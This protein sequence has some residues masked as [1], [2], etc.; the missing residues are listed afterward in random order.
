MRKKK[1]S[2]YEKAEEK[3][4][5]ITPHVIQECEYIRQRVCKSPHIAWSVLLVH[6]KVSND[7]KCQSCPCP[8]WTLCTLYYFYESSQAWNYPLTTHDQGMGPLN[9]SAIPYTQPGPRKVTQLLNE[10][11]IFLHQSISLTYHH[12]EEENTQ[13]WQ[14]KG[15]HVG[16]DLFSAHYISHYTLY[17]PLPPSL[18]RLQ[19]PRTQKKH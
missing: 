14:A 1:V 9:Y 6:I 8:P 17:K 2:F 13:V 19:Y 4:N 11:V 16:N 10:T 18:Q 3:Q 15:Q 12:H 5:K 7:M